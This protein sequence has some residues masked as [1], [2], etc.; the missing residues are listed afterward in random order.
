MQLTCFSC[1]TKVVVSA[2]HAIV[3]Q[4]PLRELYLYLQDRLLEVFA[5]LQRRLCTSYLLELDTHWS[6]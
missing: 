3:P 6:V 2:A 1:A 4:S 5:A